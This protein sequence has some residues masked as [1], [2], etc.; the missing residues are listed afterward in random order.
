MCFFLLLLLAIHDNTLPLLD[1][2]A[3]RNLDQKQR[4]RKHSV[5]KA[6]EEIT[7]SGIKFHA[8]VNEMVCSSNSSVCPNLLFLN[9]TTFTS[10]G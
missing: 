5:G 3:F 4:N 9:L 10:P 2:V 7:P 8:D 6:L 1:L